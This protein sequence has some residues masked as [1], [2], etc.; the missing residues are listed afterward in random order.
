MRKK[1][2]KICVYAIFVVILHSVGRIESVVSGISS[3]VIG[4]GGQVMGDGRQVTGTILLVGTGTL[5][6]GGSVSG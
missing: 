6:V 5:A 2:S 4:Y 3:R 1:L